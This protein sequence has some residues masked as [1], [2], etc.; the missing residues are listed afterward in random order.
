[1]LTA[2]EMNVLLNLSPLGTA[3]LAWFL[4]DERLGV[5]QIIGIVAVIV[6]VALVQLEG[7]PDAMG[8]AR[9]KPA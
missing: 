3:V 1:V 6:G 9:R 4:L 5:I 8:G 2:L 7:L